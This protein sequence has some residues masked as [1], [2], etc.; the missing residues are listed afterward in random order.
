MNAV[1]DKKGESQEVLQKIQEESEKQALP[2]QKQVFLVSEKIRRRVHNLPS[3]TRPPL[4]YDG[5]KA[6]D[7]IFP[8]IRILNSF[9][10]IL[11]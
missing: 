6:F 4:G 1:K 11:C 3:P 8:Y 5:H 9:Y 2:E 10:F 7:R